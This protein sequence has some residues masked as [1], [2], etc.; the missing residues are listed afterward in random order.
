VKGMADGAARTTV[1]GNV[2]SR[3]G[4]AYTAAGGADVAAASVSK[5]VPGMV[6]ADPS[7]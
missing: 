4:T 1:A 5:T 2:Y 6:H 3:R 7:L